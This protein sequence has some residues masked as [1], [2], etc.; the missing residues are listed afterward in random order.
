MRPAG[1]HVQEDWGSRDL[2][3]AISTTMRY[4]AVRIPGCLQQLE[5]FNGKKVF[6]SRSLRGLYKSLDH[7]A[8]A[9]S[10]ETRASV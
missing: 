10:Y 7:G 1:V 2:L 6:G 5:G 3:V 4:I 8:T 9:V